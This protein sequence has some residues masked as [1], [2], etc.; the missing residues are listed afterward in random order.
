MEETKHEDDESETEEEK[1]IKKR[2]RIKKRVEMM[3]SKEEKTYFPTITINTK[4][5]C[6]G[7]VSELLVKDENESKEITLKNIV[8][9]E[10]YSAQLVLSKDVVKN[11]DL[12]NSDILNPKNEAVFMVIDKQKVPIIIA[13]CIIYFK[14]SSGNDISLNVGC[15]VIESEDILNFKVVSEQVALLYFGYQLNEQK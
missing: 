2:Q 5:G 13:E 4:R 9:H 14:N 10:I 1:T 8:V 7:F 3:F 12:K 6:I 11:L 15:Y